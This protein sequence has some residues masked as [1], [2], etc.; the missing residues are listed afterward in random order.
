MM[1]DKV[2]LKK[3]LLCAGLPLLGGILVSLAISTETDIYDSFVKPPLSPPAVLFPI[4]WSVLYVLM[5]VALYGVMT[6]DAEMIVKQNALRTFTSQLLVN[7]LWPIIFFVIK[8]YWAAVACLIFLIILV[9]LTYREFRTIDKKSANL[10]IPYL[11]WLVFALYLN[12]GVA[13][14]N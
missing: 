10:L 9:M 14:L 3:L 13:I 5:G 4:V 12:I 11:I 1:K 6:S 7:Y 2:K 8:T